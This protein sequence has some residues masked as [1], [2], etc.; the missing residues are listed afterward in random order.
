M[1]H[2]GSLDACVKKTMAMRWLLKL[3]A[4]GCLLTAG[5]FASLRADETDFHYVRPYGSRA[6]FFTPRSSFA[7]IGGQVYY[8]PS[9]ASQPPPPNTWLNF[10]HPYT[11]AYVSVPV[12]LPNGMPKVEHRNDRLIYDYGSVAVVFH[13]V[14]DGSVN[15]SYDL[16]S[17]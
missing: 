15:V 13:F 10:R 1:L 16:K 5:S 7:Y 11:H 6:M 3:A 2:S 8:P 12:A 9:P 4:L 17:R 14:R